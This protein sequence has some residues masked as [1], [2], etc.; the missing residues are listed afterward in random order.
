MIGYLFPC[1]ARC[2]H[3]SRPASMAGFLPLRLGL[4]FGGGGTSVLIRFTVAYLLLWLTPA[5]CGSFST[6]IDIF[7]LHR[8]ASSLLLRL[9]S[10]A[11][12]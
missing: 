2:L 9:A 3:G 4:C 12:G 11:F 8:A 1:R 10:C 7:R 5:F 6:S